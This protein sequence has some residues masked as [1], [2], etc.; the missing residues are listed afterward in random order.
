MKARRSGAARREAVRRWEAAGRPPCGICG[1][2][3]DSD[4]PHE[5]DHIVMLARGGSSDAGNLRV[6]HRVCN[7][8]AA[9]AYLSLVALLTGRKLG[10]ASFRVTD[11]LS[12]HNGRDIDVAASFRAG[13]LVRC[14]PSRSPLVLLT[15][16][17]AAAAVNRRMAGAAARR[18]SAGDRIA[19]VP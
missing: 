18:A 13:K 15:R 8:A 3:I 1:T 6:V 4:E 14:V 19:D 2:P 5:A 11:A 7:L 16:R 10:V 9:N 17:R 12:A